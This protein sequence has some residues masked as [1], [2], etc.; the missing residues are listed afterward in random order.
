MGCQFHERRPVGMMDNGLEYGLQTKF[1]KTIVG[2]ISRQVDFL[3]FFELFDYNILFVH[4]VLISKYK[5][6]SAVEAHIR[7][8]FFISC[9]SL[10]S[11]TAK[12]AKYILRKVAEYFLRKVLRNVGSVGETTCRACGRAFAYDTGTKRQ[13]SYYCV[14]QVRNKNLYVN[15]SDS[16]GLSRPE[17]IT[18][19]VNDKFSL[20]CVRIIHMVIGQVQF[21]T[22]YFW[23]RRH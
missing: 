17:N 2:M 19:E 22:I 23:V 16:S 4:F 15:S 3:L 6:C 9:H 5:E 7:T 21:L 20:R 1:L 11:S 8:Y 13:I 10:V 18:L 14:L 12:L